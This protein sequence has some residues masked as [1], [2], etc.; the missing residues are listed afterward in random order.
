MVRDLPDS[1]ESSRPRRLSEKI[2]KQKITNI[3]RGK[4]K[5]NLDSINEIT[6][7]ALNGFTKRKMNLKK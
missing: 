4:I 7:R 1:R 2:E 3:N 5:E 6:N